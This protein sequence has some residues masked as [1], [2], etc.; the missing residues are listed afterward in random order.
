M[1]LF[2]FVDNRGLACR[3]KIVRS[4]LCRGFWLIKL[5]FFSFFFF[6]ALSW[7]LRWAP[8]VLFLSYIPCLLSPVTPPQTWATFPSSLCL[9]QKLEP[10]HLTTLATGS[11]TRSL[12]SR[13]SS[14][15]MGTNVHGKVTSSRKQG[16]ECDERGQDGKCYGLS[17][18]DPR[19]A[20]LKVELS[21][22]PWAVPLVGNHTRWSV[23]K[24][25]VGHKSTTQKARGFVK[26]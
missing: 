15:V 13:T 16:L 4:V 20:H 6:K 26:S 24:L 17:H 22:P 3:S 9:W 5:F 21:L 18:A 14:L 8:F 19:L 12:L 7:L 2:C 1:S 25:A 10:C 11:G 23:W